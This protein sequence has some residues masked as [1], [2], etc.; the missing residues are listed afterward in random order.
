[1]T[2]SVTRDLRTD[3]L[4]SDTQQ[5][6][7]DRLGDQTYDEIAADLGVAPGTVRSHVARIKAKT[8]RALVTLETSPVLEEVL[9]EDEYRDVREQLRARI[10]D[11]ED[12]RIVELERRLRKLEENE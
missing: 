8:R 7:I 4:F 3:T 9:D 11:T 6:V 10:C 1:M 2:T 5:K 12:D